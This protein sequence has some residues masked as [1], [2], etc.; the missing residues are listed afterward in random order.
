MP[1]ATLTRT[2]TVPQNMRLPISDVCCENDGAHNVVKN[3]LYFQP[4][5]I[6][7]SGLH[8]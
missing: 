7:K 4:I 5:G 1:T 2:H 8:I 3:D 6:V